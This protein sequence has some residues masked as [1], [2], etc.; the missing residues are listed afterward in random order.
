MQQLII[1]HSEV[2]SRGPE[3]ARPTA[4][5]PPALYGCWVW[6]TI[7]HSPLG[8][9]RGLLRMWNCPCC[10]GS[11]RECKLFPSRN[12]TWNNKKQSHFLE[13]CLPDAS[14]PSTGIT[15]FSLQ[16]KSHRTLQVL[17][18]SDFKLK[19]LIPSAERKKRD[20]WGQHKPKLHV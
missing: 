12:R 10:S 7:L 3:E 1:P 14:S 17:G 9:Q 16:L 2:N 20:T 15:D 6:T 4:P 5:V 18:N 11:F 13:P 19:L 8:S